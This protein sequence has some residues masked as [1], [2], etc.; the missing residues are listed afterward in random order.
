M[1]KEITK[2]VEARENKMYANG[3]DREFFR[4]YCEDNGELEKAMKDLIRLRDTTEDDRVRVD[5][6]KYIISQLI[7]NPKQATEIEAGTGI[8]ITVKTGV[9][10]E[11]ED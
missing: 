4:L 11:E 8:E 2:Q 7:G 10:D 9:I 5:I 3:I 6:N 1:A